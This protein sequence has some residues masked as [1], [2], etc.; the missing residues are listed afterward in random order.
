M[1]INRGVLG[2]GVFFIVLGLVPLAVRANLVDAETVRR[3]W[4]LW[5]LIL[6]GIGLGLVLQRTK[7]AFV[8]G[9]IVALTFGLMAGGAIAGGFGPVAGFGTCGFGAG[10][11]GGTPFADQS[12]TLGGTSRVS[13]DLSCGELTAGSVSGSDWRLTGT[14]DDGTPPDLTT[15]DT[16]LEIRAPEHRGLDLAHGSSWNLTL[17]QDPV[18]AL[19]VSVNAGSARLDLGPAHVSDLSLSVNA[20]DTHADLSAALGLGNVSASVNAGSLSISLPA[21]AGTLSASL[22]ANA[23]SVEVCVPSGVA[24][25]IR[26]SDSPL[27][28]NNFGSRGLARNGDTW[29]SAGFDTSAQRLELSASANLG[30]ITL[31][32]ES[33]CD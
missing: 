30:A 29:T 28:S 11:G 33:G 23:G 12:G 31:N 26:S 9:L 32:P 15:S 18:I 24:L 1:R 22:S 25:R 16:R 5:P 7:A 13:I 20:G 27:G 17:P 3:A 2:W 10:T 21:P 19:S 8:G 4:Q 6:I 14:S